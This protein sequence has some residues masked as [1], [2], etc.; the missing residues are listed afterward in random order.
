MAEG[1]SELKRRKWPLYTPSH[2]LPVLQPAG[3]VG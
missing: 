3:V 2:L 1:Q